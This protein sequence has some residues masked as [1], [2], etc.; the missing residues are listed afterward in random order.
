LGRVGTV[1]EAVGPMLFLL[2]S[3]ADYV[4]GALLEVNG[5]AHIS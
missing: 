4:S 1:D 3:H 2:S 5:G